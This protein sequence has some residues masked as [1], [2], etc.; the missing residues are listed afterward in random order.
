MKSVLFFSLLIA[1]FNIATVSGSESDVYYNKAHTNEFINEFFTLHSELSTV[2][3]FIYLAKKDK[4]NNTETYVSKNMKPSLSSF[5]TPMAVSCNET[6]DEVCTTKT[7]NGRIIEQSCKCVKKTS[8][9]IGG[10]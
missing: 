6:E 9:G 10:F 8:G 2:D 7:K 4:D 3:S 1:T 5:Y